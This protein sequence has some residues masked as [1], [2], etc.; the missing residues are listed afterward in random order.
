MSNAR[1][2]II[3]K[4]SDLNGTDHLIGE[5]DGLV[6]KEDY[7]LGNNE[8]IA[9]RLD[10]KQFL[11]S[12]L[13]R[14]RRHRSTRTGN[15]DVAAA[16]VGNFSCRAN[17]SHGSMSVSLPLK[18]TGKQHSDTRRGSKAHKCPTNHPLR[19]LNS[20]ANRSAIVQA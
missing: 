5:A 18:V 4:N 8:Q 2:E 19:A 20:R 6:A 16:V 12:K 3:P 11:E 1:S 7:Q 9:T 13:M 10:L 14:Q 17:N 15:F